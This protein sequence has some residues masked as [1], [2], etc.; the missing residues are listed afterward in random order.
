MSI[1]TRARRAADGVRASAR[2]VNPM[3]KL[4]QLKRDDKT[5]RRAGAVVA[6]A[7]VATAVVLG[8][9]FAAGNRPAPKDPVQPAGPMRMSQLEEVARGFINA[10][11]AYD[12]DRAMAYLTDGAIAATWGSREEFRQDIAWSEAV[13]YRE[14][15]DHCEKADDLGSSQRISCSFDLHALRSDELWLGPF[16][17][18]VWLFSVR[19]G[20]IREAEKMLAYQ[21]NGFS[22]Q[23]WEPFA[24]WVKTNHPD[25]VEVMYT[26]ASQSQQAHTAE[27]IT[28]WDQRT[29][30]YAAD[31]LRKSPAAKYVARVQDVCAAAH[32]RVSD[33]GG[34]LYYTE[35]WGHIL[36][37]ALGQLR[38]IPPPSTLRAEVDRAYRLVDQLA[39][40]MISGN[41]SVKVLHRVES[42]ELGLQ[43]CTFHG[44]R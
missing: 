3:T 6:V 31:K 34:T 9:W 18:N 15:I 19:D 36:A 8:G 5:R 20:K 33:L 11:S 17:D 25:D 41:V 24:A 23:M 39:E 1:D 12:A 27:A 28:L 7:V 16:P 35:A 13:G 30:D 37:D 32:E 22:Q 43:E 44:P 14:I 38:S 21:A 4:A 26:D 29:R 40:G 10:Y 42:S 2:G